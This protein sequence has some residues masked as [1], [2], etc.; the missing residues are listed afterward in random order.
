MSERT[1]YEFE[2]RGFAAGVR[3]EGGDEFAGLA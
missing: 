3:A 1:G 2:E